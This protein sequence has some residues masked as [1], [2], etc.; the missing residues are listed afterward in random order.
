M[1]FGKSL[2]LKNKNK[3]IDLRLSDNEIDILNDALE[4]VPQSWNLKTRSD[5]IRYGLLLVYDR[6]LWFNE[7][8]DLAKGDNVL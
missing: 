1:S 7:N 3:R 4:K 5:I 8:Q 6:I 2:Y